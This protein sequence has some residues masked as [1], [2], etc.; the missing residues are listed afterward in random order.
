MLYFL[1]VT[2]VALNLAIVFIIIFQCTPVEATWNFTIRGHCY[3]REHLFGPVGIVQTSEYLILSP[4]NIAY[5][6]G[7][8]TN[9]ILSLE[10]SHRYHPSNLS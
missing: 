5:G 6:V 8:L 3:S 10:W 4:I 2:N 1:A 7:N 9:T